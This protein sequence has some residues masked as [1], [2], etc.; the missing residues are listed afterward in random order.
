MLNLKCILITVLFG[1]LGCSDISYKKDQEASTNAS[2]YPNLVKAWEEFAKAVLSEDFEQI[3]SLSTNCIKCS[4]CVENTTEERKAIDTIE[5]KNPDAW[6]DKRYNELSYIPIDRFIKEDFN[7]V[8]DKQL[9]S[10]FLDESKL[11][12]AT[13][14]KTEYTWPERCKNKELENKTSKYYEVL[15]LYRDPLNKS[16]D[17]AS[18][19][20]Y[21]FVETAGVFKFFGYSTIP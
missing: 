18:Q 4:H 1:L 14:P 13:G 20:A 12:F 10:R 16:G 15:V 19:W 9:K 2:K 5:K 6:Y 11:I 8:F 21:A 17:G 3:K 7:I